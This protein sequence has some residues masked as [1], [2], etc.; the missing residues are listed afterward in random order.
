MG[1]IAQVYR[2]ETF[3]DR[4]APSLKIQK[5]PPTPELP[6]DFKQVVKPSVELN[7]EDKDTLWERV[8][9]AISSFLEKIVQT[10]REIASF[11]AYSVNGGV[12]N[13]QALC[14]FGGSA[15][16]FFK[17]TTGVS[18]GVDKLGTALGVV[19]SVLNW[20]DLV[21]DLK[22]WI[23]PSVDPHDGQKKMFWRHHDVS[24][25]KIA[26]R[27]FGTLQK[28]MSSLG[29]IMDLGLSKLGGIGA[30]IGQFSPFRIIKDALAII[31]GSLSIADDG[32]K[33]YNYRIEGKIEAL[34]LKKWE[35]KNRLN[36]FIQMTDQEKAEKVAKKFADQPAGEVNADSYIT[37]LKNKYLEIR[38]SLTE[39]GA[40]SK[41]ENA[42]LAERKWE[43]TKASYESG[44]IASLE[45]SKKCTDKIEEKE[46]K[47]EANK[48][49]KR[50]TWLNIAFQAVKT[51]ALVL[52]LAA[53]FAGLVSN[54]IMLG[55]VA[56][57]WLVTGV[58][59][60]VK[61]YYSYKHQ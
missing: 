12:A 19:D 29:S 26:S 45:I 44:E 30:A 5:N 38:S 11:L 58:V 57:A 37:K 36:E 33:S 46:T 3:L 13:L 10:V 22:S 2:P 54:P 59:G 34:K 6:V 23:V 20:G 25:L 60:F 28:I 8:K 40:K 51:A 17:G 9:V 7:K 48:T 61:M 49:T 53:L 31:S 56:A 4:E 18:E 55:V 50:K 1:T 39:L 42:P 16:K 21:V 32:I 15:V 24:R 27:I 14:K 35:L 47:I 41:K 43:M 52:G